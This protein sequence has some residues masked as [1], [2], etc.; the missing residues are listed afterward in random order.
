MVGPRRR[1]GWVRIGVAVSYYSIY[2]RPRQLAAS[3]ASQESLKRANGQGDVSDELM[4]TWG[5][6]RT[7]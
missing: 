1:L 4:E 2:D 6:L 3:M 7:S 5:V